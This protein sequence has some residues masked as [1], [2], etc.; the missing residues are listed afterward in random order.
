LPRILP[1]PPLAGLRAFEAVIRLG[2]FSLAAAELHVSTSAVSHQIRTLEADLGLRLVDRSTGTGGLSVTTEGQRLLRA[3]EA[4][5]VPL[6]QACADLRSQRQRRRRR[7]VVSAN[8]SFSSLWL[9]PRLTSFSSLHEGLE[10][11]SQVFDGIPNLPRAGIDLALI[12]LQTPL[13]TDIVLLRETLFP[14]CSPDLHAAIITGTDLLAHRLLQ[15]DH[16]ESPE[17]DWAT[18]FALLGVPASPRPS[19]VRF[20]AFSS[21]VGAAIAGTG[22]ALGRWPLIDFELRSGR[23]KRLF[24]R[25]RLD[26]SWSYVMRRRPA[27]EGDPALQALCTFLAREAQAE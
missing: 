7:L 10:V 17:T 23:L 16:E 5:L 8:G 22:V 14:V 21:V 2:G 25:I 4:A 12:H 15:E 3:I 9:A 19:I 27:A 26:G 24:P 18:W 13:D 1:L 20:G 6:G 11:R